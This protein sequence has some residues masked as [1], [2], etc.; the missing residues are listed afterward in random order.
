M[1]TSV[2]YPSFKSLLIGSQ[3]NIA[4][5]DLNVVLVTSAYTA[6]VSNGSYRNH[7]T[8]QNVSSVTSAVASST[9]VQLNSPHTIEL[10][11]DGYYTMVKTLNDAVWNQ[12]SITAT[13]AVVYDDSENLICYVD[14]GTTK[15]STN[16]SFVVPFTRGVLQIA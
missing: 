5:A 13:G 1:A 4:T 2:V 14:F 9:I 6:T 7:T 11:D 3:Y 8:Y 15:I 10:S 16:S 12:S